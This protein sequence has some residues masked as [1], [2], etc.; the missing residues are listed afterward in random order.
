[1]KTLRILGVTV[2]VLGVAL[3]LGVLPVA[4][5]ESGTPERCGRGNAMA[6]FQNFETGLNAVDIAGPDEDG[7]LVWHIWRPAGLGDAVRNC[8]YRVWAAMPNSGWPK[9]YR[10]CAN[11]VFVGGNIHGIQYQ[12]PAVQEM[13]DESQPDVQ[14]SYR[15]K[16]IAELER[17][18]ERTFVTRL[19]YFD[20]SGQERPLGDG[21]NGDPVSSDPTAGEPKAQEMMHTVFKDFFVGSPDAA[22]KKVLRQV[23]YFGQL[24]AG[25]YS[26]QTERWKD[27]TLDFKFPAVKLDIV[28]CD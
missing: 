9:Q 25:K 2:S 14:G 4:A 3:Q 20:A 11:D 17:Y 12:H 6:V 15:N 24:E 27:G 13:L 1:M 5:Q 16:A 10:F 22:P 8:Q 19:T 21:G 28:S 18:D 7:N 26:S 23:A